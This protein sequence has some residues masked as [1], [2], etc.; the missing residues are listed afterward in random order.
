MDKFVQITFKCILSHVVALAVF[1]KISGEKK[2]SHILRILKH[3]MLSKSPSRHYTFL[4]FRATWKSLPV[5]VHRVS[6]LFSG[7][8]NFSHSQQVLA[9]DVS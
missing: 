2:V 6:S 1:K 3:I 7:K 4:T 9:H 5:L 8:V